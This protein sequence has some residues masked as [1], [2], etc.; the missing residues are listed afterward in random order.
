MRIDD[1]DYASIAE[2]NIKVFAT[3]NEAK[4]IEKICDSAGYI[5]ELSLLDI[6]SCC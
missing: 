4:L 3:E 1:E 5:P 6:C 2:V